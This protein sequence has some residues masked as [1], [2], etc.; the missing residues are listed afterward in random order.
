M[1]LEPRVYLDDGC[2]FP[3]GDACE[4]CLLVFGRKNRAGGR[5]LQLNGV[6]SVHREASILTE[7]GIMGDNLAGEALK[8]S[9]EGDHAPKY[10]KT[11]R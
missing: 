10:N 11:R 7:L 4:E 6:E 5:L 9:N 1:L 8:Y 2:T 3:F